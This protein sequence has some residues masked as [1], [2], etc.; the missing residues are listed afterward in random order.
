MG[1]TWGSKSEEW[2]LHFGFPADVPAPRD[3]AFL[4]NRIRELL[5]I[6][7]L[8]LEILQCSSW[9]FDRVVASKF[10]SGNCFIIGDAAHRIP[11]A[12]GLGLNTAIEDALNIAFKF[13]LIKRKVATTKLLDSYEA[14]RKPVAIRNADWGLHCLS[15]F[16][17]LQHAVGFQPGNEAWNGMR[18][19]HLFGDSHASKCALHAVRRIIA[20]QDIEFQARDLELGFR[21][22]MPGAAIVPS[23]DVDFKAVEDDPTGKTY[24]QSCRPGGRLPHVAIGFE[25]KIHSTQDLFRIL[26]VRGDFLLITDRDGAAQWREAVS[27]VNRACGLEIVPVVAVIADCSAADIK[28]LKPGLVWIEESW[29]SL[30]EHGDGG[31]ILVRGDNFVAW[32]TEKAAN[33]KAAT[34]LLTQVMCKLLCVEMVEEQQRHPW[35]FLEKMVENVRLKVC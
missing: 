17:T 5:N 14:E 24:V 15:H 16:P 25:G 31:A 34:L 18:M 32:A 19:A 26:P 30:R 13:A 23:R 33:K 11:P 3:P 10:Q 20:T 8:E 29:R 35:E 1:P 27:K 21:Y 7:D 9:I 2:S 4:A 12:G 28:H 6:P 22:D